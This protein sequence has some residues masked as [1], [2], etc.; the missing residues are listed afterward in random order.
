MFHKVLRPQ[1]PVS[2]SRLDAVHPHPRAQLLQERRGDADAL[3]GDDVEGRGEARDPA[4]VDG[5]EVSV[6]LPIQPY[7]PTTG[8]PLRRPERIQ[9]RASTA[10]K[11]RRNVRRCRST[12][13]YQ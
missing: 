9:S 8:T 6:T 11:I 10:S 2:E 12:P 1:C 3:V 7:R 5:D 13:P 4:G